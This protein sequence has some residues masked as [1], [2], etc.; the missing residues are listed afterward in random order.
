MKIGKMIMIGIV[1]FL[2]MLGTA[3]AGAKKQVRIGTE[4]AYPPFNQ[5]DSSGKLVGFDIDIANAL[6]TAAGFECTFVVQDWD[7]II[8][9]LIAKKYDAI[10]ASMLITEDRM[11]KVNFTDK[12]YMTPV[13]FVKPKSLKIDLPGDNA[14]A[15]KIL[16]GKTVGVQ[17]ATSQE[18][19]LRD[20][21]PDVKVKVYGTQDDANLDL[22]NGRVDLVIADSMVLLDGFLKT[23]DGKDFEFVGRDYLDRKWLGEGNGIAI[24]K[25]ETELLNA[26][27]A[28]LKQILKDGTY[29][30][31]NDAYFDFNVYG[32]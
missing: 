2:M 15:N 11:K 8:P 3:G 22:V 4:G 31:I 26:F 10:I 5:I 25:G 18:N 12:Y 1:A 16:S 21:F 19:F 23:P 7:G 30:K 29:K 9:G 28:A 17:R 13:K 20:N 24:R 27:N 14:K 32:D 6:C